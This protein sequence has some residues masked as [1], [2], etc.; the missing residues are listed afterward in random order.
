MSERF[1]TRPTCF[2]TILSD[3][4]LRQEV[5]QAMFLRKKPLVLCNATQRQKLKTYRGFFH[6]FSHPEGLPLDTRH[7]NVFLP[8]EPQDLKI[9]ASEPYRRFFTALK[10]GTVVT[11]LCDFGMIQDLRHSVIDHSFV[12]V[13]I[14]EN[15]TTCYFSCVKGPLL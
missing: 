2:K 15:G 11:V 9:V 5:T 6:I 13:Y 3:E 12:N 10:P 8:L 4:D 1:S 7:S 14:L